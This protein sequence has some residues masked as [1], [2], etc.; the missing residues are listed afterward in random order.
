MFWF[1]RGYNSEGQRWLERAL[2]TDGQASAA[3]RAKALD[4]L[5]VLADVRE[6]MDRAEAAA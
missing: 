2:T 4:A 3:A 6:D 1:A 5:A